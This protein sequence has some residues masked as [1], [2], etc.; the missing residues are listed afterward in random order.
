MPTS[1]HDDVLTV[2]DAFFA[3]EADYIRAGWPGVADFGGMAA[4]LAPDV[5]IHQAPSLP[6]GGAWRGHDGFERFMAAM[7][8]A[9]RSLE[10]LD[11]RQWVDGDTVVI[12]NHGRLTA[13]ATGR[14]IETTVLQRITVR[15][16]LIA[17]LWPFYWD[18]AAVS[19][20]LTRPGRG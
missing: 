16:G 5:V 12:S 9:W 10:F 2:L 6:Y 4:H 1:G 8:E 7:S 20:A 13:R 3:A 18:T 19:D 14:S 17:E 11:R 15:D